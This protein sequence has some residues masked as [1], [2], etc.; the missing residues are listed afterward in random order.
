MRHLLFI[1]VMGSGLGLTG[2][3]PAVV[4]EAEGDSKPP[5]TRGN[6]PVDIKSASLSGDILELS[7]SYTGGCERHSF[8]LEWDGIFLTSSP[9]QVPIV[10]GHD[11]RGD[12]CEALPSETRR[13]DLTPLKEAWR[14]GH[15]QTEGSM[16]IRI[17]GTPHSVLYTF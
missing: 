7:L 15:Q 1:A 4:V 16:S 10:L 17:Q 8:W 13:F 12:R 14:Q 11:A 6:D 2:C 5:L 9:V 3:G